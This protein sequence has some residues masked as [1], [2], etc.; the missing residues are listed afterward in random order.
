MA[1]DLEA[2]YFDLHEHPELSF[3]EHRTAAVVAERMTDLGLEVFAGIAGTGV[4]AVLR[5]GDG[6]TV[7]LRADMDGLP[8]HEET[9]LPY[10]SEARGVDPMGRDVPV[11]HACGHDVHM[12]CLV[13]AVERLVDEKAQWRGTLI[14]VFQPSEER[15][16]GAKAM[17]EDGLYDKVPTPDVVLGQHVSGF[18]AGTVVVHSGP[19]MAAVN[20]ITARMFGQGGHGSR[21]ETAIDPVVM[22][23]AA[24]MRLQTVVSRE[25]SPKQTAVVSVG[26][27]HAGT[28]SNIIPAEATLEIS[29]RSF[30]PDVRA[31]LLAS[32]ERIIRAES[33]ASA[34][35]RPPEFTYGEDYPV[36]FNDPDATER[37]AG[38]L[39]AALGDAHVGDPG[40]ITGSE[41]VGILA[42]AVGAPLVYW[43]LGG[44]APELFTGPLGTI[45]PTLPANHSPLF[46]PLP[47]PTIDTGVT[48]LV[49]AAREWL[50]APGGA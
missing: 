15:D 38:A 41:D 48:A 45:E 35:P 37:T 49:A 29:L 21:P 50:G 27:I 28:K 20:A 1:I 18:P 43:F 44:F 11:M 31:K 2:L 39:R 40:Q 14:A 12:T 32:V 13:G 6:P 23:A 47:Q 19:A 46:A 42:S 30:D 16:G 25:I 10:A 22:A 7:L 36:T 3:A 26:A 17:V 33:D 24:V 4:A 8:V 34:A 5:N 9:G